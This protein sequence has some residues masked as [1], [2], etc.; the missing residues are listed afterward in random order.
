MM[1]WN[2]QRRP[3]AQQALR[4]SFFQVGQYIQ[5]KKVT[6]PNQTL[7]KRASLSNFSSIPENIK[8][9]TNNQEYQELNMSMNKPKFDVNNLNNKAL[10]SKNPIENKEAFSFEPKK[11]EGPSKASQSARRRWNGPKEGSKATS[12]SID[13][14]ESILDGLDGSKTHLNQPNKRVN[15]F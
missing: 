7:Q 10:L 3:T 13:E 5:R 14:F 15:L 8:E 11:P 2:P 6:L 1:K 9:D 4:Y 12:D